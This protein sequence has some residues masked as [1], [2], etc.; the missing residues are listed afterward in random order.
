MVTPN[1]KYLMQNPKDPARWEALEI[2][3]TDPSQHF[4]TELDTEGAVRRRD[5]GGFMIVPSRQYNSALADVSDAVRR[6]REV[7]PPPSGSSAK[8]ADVA[9]EAEAEGRS[10]GPAMM[11]ELGD[12]RAALAGY[13]VQPRA[14]RKPSPEMLAQA[15]AEQDGFQQGLR[16]RGEPPARGDTQSRPRVAANGVGDMPAFRPPTAL[17]PPSDRSEPVSE[18]E[19]VA[20]RTATP[21]RDEEFAAA[22]D[23]ANRRG[24]MA[25]LGRAGARLNEAFTGVGGDTAFYDQLARESDSPVRQLLAQREA[26][27]R[28]ALEDP[29][30]EQSQRI[31]AWVSKALPGVY[32]QEEISQMTAGDA[33][34][35]TRYGEM[36]QRLDQRAAD[37]AAQQTLRADEISR[38][39]RIREDEQT[40][41]STE[42]QKD[43]DLQRELARRRGGGGGP[44]TA[45]AERE[46]TR[47]EQQ[48]RQLSE[49]FTK[50]DAPAFYEQFSQVDSIMR[51]NPSD[52]PG[53]GQLAGRLPDF[54]TSK[55]GVQLRQ[56]VGQM[57]AAYRKAVTGAGMSDAE[58]AEYDRITGL[59]QS[60]D[61]ASVREGVKLMK[62]AMDARIRAVAGGY[63]PEA[64][65]TYGERVPSFA[66]AV[67]Q[68]GTQAAPQSSSR[69]A[70]GKV[71]VS[72]G[73]ETLEIDPADLAEAQRDGFREVT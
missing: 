18:A 22:Q 46:Q 26:D 16:L 43:R 23:E 19:G 54:A 34:M 64:V 24:L 5:E 10:V 40:F 48:T 29:S 70:P 58:R 4:R 51:D 30:S 45:A 52:L 67:G 61:E 56:A 62:N 21:T 47:I 69:A 57:L 31:Q 27:K 28:R 41:R 63:R 65:S 60:G 49:E 6:K 68:Q 32:T 3:A 37:R 25:G 50:I 33:D 13:R 8:A 59:V 72:N 9:R 17:R 66:R 15:E 20:V 12:E 35:V 42:A 7:P 38:E 2:L 39:D 36:R 53:F 11:A 1:R 55:S 44:N 14:F 73:R 71:R